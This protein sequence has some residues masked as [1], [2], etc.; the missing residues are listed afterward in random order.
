LDYGN[1]V[2]YQNITHGIIAFLQFDE[3]NLGELDDKVCQNGYRDRAAGR[4]VPNRSFETIK[5]ENRLF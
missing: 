4:Q 3:N 2:M 5:L 1:S